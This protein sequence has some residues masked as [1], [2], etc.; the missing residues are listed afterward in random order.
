[1][2]PEFAAIILATWLAI[3]GLS[4]AAIVLAYLIWR[5]L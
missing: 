3:I 2:T 5:K 4:I 1:M